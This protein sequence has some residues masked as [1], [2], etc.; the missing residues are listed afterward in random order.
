MHTIFNSLYNFLFFFLGEIFYALF[1]LNGCDD[2]EDDTII[3]RGYSIHKN[4]NLANAK[5]SGATLT[6]AN[7][8]YAI[9]RYADL[10]YANLRGAIL[11]YADLTGA[12]L[13]KANMTGAH[14]TGATLTD[15]DLRYVNLTSANLTGANLTGVNLEYANL[16]NVN[17][18]GANLTSVKSGGIK[19]RPKSLPPGY[20]LKEGYIVGPNGETMR[21]KERNGSYKSETTS[22]DINSIQN[23]EG[24]AAEKS[25]GEFI[26]NLNINYLTSNYGRILELHLEIFEAYHN[27]KVRQSIVHIY[28]N[29]TTNW[30]N[31][32]F[33]G[34]DT[35]N[36]M[37]N[38]YIAY[39]KTNNEAVP[40][41]MHINEDIKVKL[42]LDDPYNSN[43]LYNVENTRFDDRK[44][45]DMVE[46]K[47]NDII[48]ILAG[49]G[50]YKT[51]IN[52]IIEDKKDTDSQRLLTNNKTN[53]DAKNMM[54]KIDTIYT[55]LNEI[56]EKVVLNDDLTVEN[57]EENI[58]LNIKENNGLSDF[59]NNNDNDN[60]KLKDFFKFYGRMYAEDK[61]Y[62]KIDN[63]HY[64]TY[65]LTP[66]KNHKIQPLIV[67]STK[68]LAEFN[69]DAIEFLAGFNNIA[70]INKG[71]TKSNLYKLFEEI[72]NYLKPIDLGSSSW[73]EI[74]LLEDERKKIRIKTATKEEIIDTYNKFICPSWNDE[75]PDD[76]P[77]GC[78]D[79]DEDGVKDK[80]DKCPNTK[81]E[82]KD[83]V[84][85]NG[86]VISLPD[87]L[88]CEDGELTY[89]GPY[90]DLDDD[91][92]DET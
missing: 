30:V 69:F 89:V 80:D 67:I 74:K 92:D 56:T 71:K 88:K 75:T 51:K 83:N 21:G 64:F 52:T 36:N 90:N 2:D 58:D 39:L 70:N 43:S 37:F 86:C 11:N 27:K 12:D 68:Y 62:Q 91:D 61:I 8:S 31:T 73:S 9:L 63:D 65:R 76:D 55:Y 26:T 35:Y 54:K 4:A 15:A 13:F 45:T 50:E 7:M 16:S 28:T 84:D 81:L 22:R 33:Y 53:F 59:L 42:Q 10:S 87:Y 20:Q 66:P 77:A 32:C 24:E 46:I 49:I 25:I 79:K 1:S 41:Y 23:R 44:D 14:L 6:G 78:L 34:Y 29:S 19:G 72:Y 60:N 82:D 85:E 3:V 40:E 17:L 38:N 57:I 48:R 47:Y 5:L 18:T